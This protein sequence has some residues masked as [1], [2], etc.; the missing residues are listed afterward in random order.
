MTRRGAA[1]VNGFLFLYLQG[2]AI[3]LATSAPTGPVGLMCIRR[4]LGDGR[5]AAW[6]AGF[7]AVLADTLFGA[8]VGL[9]LGAVSHILSDA[10]FGLKLGGGLFLLV[11]SIHTWRSAT[12]TLAPLP[13]SRGKTGV[14]RDFL[15]A[16]AIT[17][18][19]PGA[20]LGMFGMFAALG[21]AAQPARI[22]DGW[23]VV[24]GIFCGAAL[25]WGILTELTILVKDRLT[26][27]SIQRFNRIS[28]A[29]LFF[30]GVG[31]LGSLVVG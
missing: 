17:L 24:F 15:S 8:I 11:L 27:K 29:L 21:A 28:A 9:G 2:L 31:V 25:W 23:M 16:F 10:A 22:E 19:N 5:I 30:F 14:I 6:S 20:I 18:S 13:E 26:P 12:A 1:P 4:A 3:G 7:G